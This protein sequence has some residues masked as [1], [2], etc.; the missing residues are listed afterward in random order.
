MLEILAH[1]AL[2]ALIAEIKAAEVFPVIT[3]ETADAT[4]EEQV[5]LCFHFV[6]EKLEP[7]ELF[8]GVYETSNTTA[9]ALNG[10]IKDA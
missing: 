8:V 1:N 5:P 9:G 3:D 6:T 10:L 7:W 2:R 4:V